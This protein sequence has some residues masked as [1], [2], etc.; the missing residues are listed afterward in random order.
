MKNLYLK[1]ISKSFLFIILKIVRKN[2]NKIHNLNDR[3]YKLEKSF[4]LLKNLEKED[5]VQNS[6]EKYLYEKNLKLSH[7]LVEARKKLEIL[8]VE[9]N[10]FKNEKNKIITKLNS[11]NDDLEN[12]NVIKQVFNN[13][14]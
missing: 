6:K 8:T 12:S 4:K 10:K 2:S 13:K 5:F 14:K 3:L 7:E 1:K 11:I 9:M